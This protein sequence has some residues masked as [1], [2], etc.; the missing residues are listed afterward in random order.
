MKNLV[1]LLQ[2]HVDDWRP[3]ADEA[4]TFLAKHDLDRLPEHEERFA[5]D[6]L[7]YLCSRYAK[8]GFE[9]AQKKPDLSFIKHHD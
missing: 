1:T 6:Q 7:H 8:L 9:L 5:Y 2:E 3:L 4:I